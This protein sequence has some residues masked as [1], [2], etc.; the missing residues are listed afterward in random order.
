MVR[1]IQ[2]SS[3]PSSHIYRTPD[4]YEPVARLAV[5]FGN[6]AFG[7]YELDASKKLRG[8]QL[9]VQ[10]CLK[11]CVWWALQPAAQQ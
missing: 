8:S 6:G 9:G 2:L 1:K 7:I 3:C 5:L 10:S 11:V 4:G